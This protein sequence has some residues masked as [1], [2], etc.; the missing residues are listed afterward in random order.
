MSETIPANVALSAFP[1]TQ[2]QGFKPSEPNWTLT[3]T[4]QDPELQ[5]FVRGIT[6]LAKKEGKAAYFVLKTKVDGLWL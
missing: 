4:H 6:S 3:E 2:Q 1:Q 5:A